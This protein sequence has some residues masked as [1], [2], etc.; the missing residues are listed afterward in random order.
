[1]HA[2]PRV[3][4]R[5]LAAVFPECDP[6]GLLIVPTCQHA[7]VDLVRFGADVDAEKDRLLERFMRFAN[8]ITS[9]LTQQASMRQARMTANFVVQLHTTGMATHIVHRATLQIL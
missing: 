2:C 7:A 5:E 8:A 1:V 3:H 6:A 4:L 9:L